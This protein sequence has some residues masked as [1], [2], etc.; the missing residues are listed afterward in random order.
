MDD[1]LIEKLSNSPFIVRGDAFD[2]DYEKYLTDKAY[3]PLQD[4]L[5]ARNFTV[6][7]TG[8]AYR[9]INHWEE[10]GLLPKR[11]GDEG[12]RKF[13]YVELVWMKA[14]SRLRKL[15]FPIA[16][17]V[18]VKKA[19][20]RWDKDLGTYP[21]LEYFIVAS[22]VSLL[23]PYIFVLSDGKAEVASSREIEAYKD[24]FQSNDAIL[25]SIKSILKE[26]GMK[27]IKPE[28]LLPVSAEE[29]E[30]LYAIRHEDNNEI[31]V[32]TASHKLRKIASVETTK[33]VSENPKINEILTENAITEDDFFGEITVKYE[34]GRRQSAHVKKVRRF[35]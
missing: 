34:K 13:S 30:L 24:L 11:E 22:R 14:I 3:K 28:V 5:R 7:E 26:L 18:K 33:I 21:V 19:V 23:D 2:E 10:K 1:W 35:K 15:G 4:R 29:K 12:W 27:V 20:M 16:K 31:K 9:I 32:K 25:I 17:I 8:V 6:G